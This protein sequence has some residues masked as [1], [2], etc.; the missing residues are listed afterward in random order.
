MTRVLRFMVSIALA[1]MSWVSP[2]FAQ[3]RRSESE[4]T[5]DVPWP[6][7]V[8]LVESVAFGSAAAARSEGGATALAYYNLRNSDSP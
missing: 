7:E 3:I 5:D 1:I 2:T 4:A 8:P 6:V